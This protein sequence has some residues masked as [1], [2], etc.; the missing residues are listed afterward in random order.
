MQTSS[1]NQTTAGG[2]AIAGGLVAAISAALSW[3]DFTEEGASDRTFKGTDLNAGSIAVVC[4]I[5][6]IIFGIIL[7]VRGARTGG[8]G[9][10]VTAIVFAAFV[11]GV[12][13]YT[14]LAPADSLVAFD[15][16]DV[17]EANQVSESIA[18]AYM[19]QGFA[20]GSLTADALIGPW[21]AT[22]GGLI[23]LIGG[24]LGA[25]NSGKVKE[26]QAAAAPAPSAAEPRA[27]GTP[28]EA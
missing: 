12:A 17:A 5:V 14:A 15:A 3:I 2:L 20:N 21:V 16:S 7:V 11:L 23:A 18:K 1:P 24:I 22:A 26:Q 13:L 27:A 4:G 10:A 25:A 6:L 28:P 9:S 19:E 8:R